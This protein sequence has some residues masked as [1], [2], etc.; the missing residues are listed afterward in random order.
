MF[1]PPRRARWTAPA[2]SFLLG[3]AVVGACAQATPQKD[4]PPGGSMTT[5]APANAPS[6]MVIRVQLDVQPQ[7]RQAF[8]DHMAQESVKVRQLDGCE[9]YALFASTDAENT[10]LLYEEWATA[11]AFG[12]YQQSDLL[13]K[14]FE[15]L[16][17]MMAGKPDSAY[18][19]ARRTN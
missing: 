6:K 18:Y 2:L 7:H 1:D 15:V 13:K 12:A 17:P 8:I 11:D 14:S 3:V 4:P 19:A 9:R 5:S 10:F 16:G